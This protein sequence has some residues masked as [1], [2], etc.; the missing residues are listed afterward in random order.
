MSLTKAGL[1]NHL[2][3]S[4][5]LSKSESVQ[6]VE[7]LLKIIKDCLESGENVLISGFGKFSVKDKR[8]RRGR[9]PHTGDDLILAPRRVV[10]FRPSGVLRQ[11][12]NGKTA[13]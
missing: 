12:I 9:N 1:V 5:N 10:T 2:Y 8:A 7:S 13:E 6:A 11:K 3:T 4:K